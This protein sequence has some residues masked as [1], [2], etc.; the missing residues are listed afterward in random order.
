MTARAQTTQ[1]KR[2]W[3]TGGGSGIG[4]A[5]ALR[6]AC[7][8]WLV[9]I[10]GRTMDTLAEVQSAAKDL[11][12][13]VIALYHDVTDDNAVQDCSRALAGLTEHL[14]MIILNAGTCEYVKGQTLEPAMFRRVIDTNLFGMI[15]SFNA[16]LPLLREAPRRPLVAGICSLAA[17]IGFPHAEAYGASKAA[18]R[19]FLHSLRTDIKDLADVTVVNPG[20][21][22][23]P[24][25]AS[26]DFP[27]PFL[28]DADTAAARI[29]H[30][31][32]R[33]PLEYNFPKRLV[34]SL[35]FAQLFQGIW[36]RTISRK[37]T[38]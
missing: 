4:R 34:A 7:S 32:Q 19:Y 15:N 38:R 22:T 25:T 10:S 13:K 3:I 33:R 37:S 1:Y 17:F 24:L 5:L 26:N 23:T 30:A 29:A 12:G 27:M 16:A 20:F 28:M 18:S 36:Y 8:G 31:L 14:D 21:I 6:Y 2:V 11:P 9:I 35:R